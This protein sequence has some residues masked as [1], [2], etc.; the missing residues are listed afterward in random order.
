MWVP[1]GG[2]CATITSCDEVL[3]PSLGLL[4]AKVLIAETG[5]VSAVAECSGSSGS[6]PLTI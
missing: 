6:E 3:A 1:C 5:L 4:D 2:Q